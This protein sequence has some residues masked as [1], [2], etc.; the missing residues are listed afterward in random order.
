[1]LRDGDTRLYSLGKSQMAF[2]GLLVLLC[3]VGVF[4]LTGTMERIPPQT[5]ILLGISAATGLGAVLIGNSKKSEFHTTIE[6]LKREQQNLAGQ[7]VT[8][9][10]TA[11]VEAI[12]LEIEGLKKQMQ[13]VPSKGFWR[14][15]LDDGNIPSF[16]RFQVVLWTVVLGAVFVR[17]VAQV[18]SMPEFSETLLTLLGISNATYLGFKIPE[19]M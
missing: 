12:N 13:S 8:P 4:I 15:I 19:K 2:W 1:M 10:N 17:S 3:F 5:L 7:P 14:D 18:M 11:H 16:H 6:G 9:E